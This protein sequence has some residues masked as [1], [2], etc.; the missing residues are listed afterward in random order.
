MGSDIVSLFPAT[1]PTSFLPPLARLPTQSAKDIANALSGL[2]MLYWPP[3]SPSPC[4]QFL[5][6]AKISIEPKHLYS[7]NDFVPDSGYASAEEEDEA[8]EHGQASG[9]NSDANEDTLLELFRADPFERDFSIKWVTGFVSRSAI[10]TELATEDEEH[11]A[12]VLV[13]DEGTRLL[14]LFSGDGASHAEVPDAAQTIVRKII[15]SKKENEETLEVEMQDAPMLED[16]HTSVGLQSWGSCIR[17]G[18][19]IAKDPELFFFPSGPVLNQHEKP[20]LR[21]LELGAGTGLLSILTAKLLSREQENATIVATDYHP[22]V[23]ENLRRNVSVN[24]PAGSSVP[25][26]IVHRLDWSRP[27]CDGPLS[28]SFDIILA[29][30]VVYHPSHA[31]WLRGCVEHLLKRPN[32]AFW[33]IIAVRE[34]GRHEGLDET[35]EEVFDGAKTGIGVGVLEMEEAKR[36][37]GVGR[38]DEIGYKLFKIGWM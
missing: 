4:P 23:L 10:W 5:L 25:R 14:A 8:D 3:E 29:A 18:E 21:I 26:V 22:H 38:A 30:D 35:V 31:L 2:H 13:L 11:T 28:S 34:V 37:L 17:L 12:R 16:D 9:N 15:F 27:I 6:Q 24:I 7:L 36:Q 19:M 1:P 32:G 20:G 33:M